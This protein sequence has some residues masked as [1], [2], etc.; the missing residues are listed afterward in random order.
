MSI[1]SCLFN[2]SVGRSKFRGGNAFP[3]VAEGEEGLKGLEPFQLYTKGGKA[4]PK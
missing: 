4:L 3:V 2:V 1:T